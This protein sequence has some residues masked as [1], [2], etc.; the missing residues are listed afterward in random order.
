MNLSLVTLG[1]GSVI[2]VLKDINAMTG[3]GFSVSLIT[4]TTTACVA[5]AQYALTSGHGFNVGR[6]AKVGVLGY[7]F[8][9]CHESTV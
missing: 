9:P 8:S 6:V 4:A 2:V 3:V 1:V 7:H 5:W